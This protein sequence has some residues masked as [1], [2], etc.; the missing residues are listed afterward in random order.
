M[1]ILQNQC[2]LLQLFNKPKIV[3]SKNFLW[4]LI[5]HLMLKQTCLNVKQTSI[6]KFTTNIHKC[7]TKFNVKRNQHTSLTQQADAQVINR[8]AFYVK[9]RNL[10]KLGH[11]V[12]EENVLF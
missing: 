3:Q 7:L 6:H 4:N 8:G 12:T 11:K 1:T 5:K 9:M 10:S 2:N